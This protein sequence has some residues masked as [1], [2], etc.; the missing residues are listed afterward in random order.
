MDCTY[1]FCVINF[2]NEPAIISSD[3]SIIDFSTMGIESMARRETF[4]IV[5]F[6]SRNSAGSEVSEGKM[7]QTYR[8][9]LK[10]DVDYNAGSLTVHGT[11]DCLEKM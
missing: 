6:R 8:G 2:R 4:S 5:E 10:L 9:Q 1:I 7:Y 11:C 3:L